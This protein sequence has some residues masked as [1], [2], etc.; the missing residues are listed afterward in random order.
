M[1]TDLDLQSLANG[2]SF[3]PPLGIQGL[4]NTLFSIFLLTQLFSTI[5]QQV[6]PRLTNARELFESREQP[7][8]AYSWLIF[9]LSTILVEV[10]WQTI[11]SVLIFVC[12]YYPTGLWRNSDAT[13]SASERGALVFVMIWLFGLWITTFSQLVA[14][15][16][17]HAETAVQIAT[18]FF[19]LSLVFCG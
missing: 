19:W 18:L 10:A 17:E 6:I 8:K 1:L 7:S 16:I 9:L 11:S 13:F 2:L 12:W 3:G 15:G 14:V 5:D 4:T